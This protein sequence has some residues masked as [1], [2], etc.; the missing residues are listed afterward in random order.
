M[1]TDKEGQAVVLN[2][3][4]FDNLFR[5]AVKTTKI[6][7]RPSCHSRTPKKANIEIYYDLNAPEK[8]GYRPCKRCRPNDK[9]VDNAL[10]AIEIETILLENY[11]KNLTLEELA[12]LAH[13]SESYLRHIF[14]KM[15]GQTPNQRLMEIRMHHAKNEVLNT[16][17]KIDII[18]KDVG[19]SNVSYF[20]KKFKEHHGHSPQQFRKKY[21]T[22][23]SIFISNLPII[24]INQEKEGKGNV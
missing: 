9:I 10:W 5:Y 18:A 4:S 8:H 19:I 17:K 16:Q 12:Y 22:F 6:F 13:G 20:I 2:D 14:K 11:Q 15:T 1:I 21:P 3:A 23:A 7:C 24:S